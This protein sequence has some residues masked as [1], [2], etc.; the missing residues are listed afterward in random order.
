MIA[1]ALGYPGKT[2]AGQ[3]DQPL[4]VPEMEKV[5]ELR[6]TGR[7]ARSR[8]RLA[9][10]DRVDRAGFSRVRPTGKCDLETRIGRKLLGAA[11][12]GQ[13]TSVKN[14]GHNKARARSRL[15]WVQVD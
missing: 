5:H 15:C 7:L 12:A 3:V 10:G 1:D 6:A 11:S 4:P 14:S 2:V 9:S 13:E 8:E